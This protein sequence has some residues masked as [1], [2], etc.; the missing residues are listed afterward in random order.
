ML[1]YVFP[2]QGAQKKGMGE[3][4]FDEFKELTAQA[5]D[6]LGYSIKQLCLEDPDFNLNKTQYTQPAL[7]TVNALSYFSKMHSGRRE[8]FVAGHSLGEY[9]ALLAAG[10]FDFATGLRLVQKRGQLMSRAAGGGMAAVIGLTEEQI[11]EVLQ[12][13]KLETIDIANLNSPH[14]IVI[15]G[16]REDM[17][18][19]KQVFESLKDVMMFI[20]LRT[21]GAFHS[22]HMEEAGRE[23]EA[24]LQNFTFHELRIPVISNV[25]A[26]RYQSSCIK[27]NL[28]QQMTSSV[29]WTE[30]IRYL[31]G[32]GVIH[33]EEIGPGRV[34]TDLIGRIKNEAEP[35]IVDEPAF[36]DEAVIENL[37]EELNECHLEMS[38]KSETI[39]VEQLQSSEIKPS[40]LGSAAFRRDYNLKY[41]YMTGAMYRGIASKEMVVRMGKAGMMGFFGAGGLKLPQIV[42]A[43]Q[44]I[45]QELSEGQAYGM[46]LVHNPTEPEIEEQTVDVFLQ[47]GVK[48]MEAAAF[49]NITAALVKFRAKGLT[50][51]ADGRV[52]SINKLIAK[53]SRPEVAE[54]FL[55]PAPERIVAK[56]RGENKITPEEALML[57]EVP[58][59]DDICAEADSG[60]HTDG[61][62]AYALMPAMIKLRDEI[63]QRY[64]YPT[65]I[66]IGAAGGIGT[67]DAI[68]AAFT[69]GADFI[70]TGSINQCTVEAGTSDEVKDLLQQMN[71]QD[72]EYAPAGDMFEMG[73]RV[74]VLKKGLFFPARSNKLYDLYRQ[75]NSIDEIDDKT[76]A[77]IQEK[78]FKRSFE[79]VYETVRTRYPQVVEKA[80]RNPKY[81]MALIFRW[82]FSYS[83][84]L[85][86]QGDQENK[87]DYQIHCGPALGAFNQWVK[88]TKLEDWR[89]R[90]VDEIAEKLMTETAALL[91][92]RFNSFRMSSEEPGMAEFQDIRSAQEVY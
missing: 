86:L 42:E 47:S 18:L 25:H 27:R 71:V 68:S 74:Q 34:L 78:Y 60:G 82:Y 83:T 35:L 52:I 66:R 85:A 8:D 55:S 57:R 58:V 1:A 5:D 87:V 62:V 50:R 31:M 23:Y 64:S 84:R 13:H 26:R 36:V 59:A 75:Y 19:A 7:Y 12:E 16:A 21:S 43:I 61:A 30:S 45:Q 40:S 65:R 28:V 17:D 3:E 89:N 90:H 88:G 77:Q 22:R 2:G 37:H 41:A 48:V 49:M 72:T 6:I 10:A 53:V 73:A 39:A 79:S 24:F 54:A 81:K 20:P 29:R 51:D 92:R 67:P 91:N 4:L 33:F 63:M 14:Q 46:N 44:Y 15:S 9:N 69:L 70:V 80:E 76:K 32:L 56:L 11:A 38:H